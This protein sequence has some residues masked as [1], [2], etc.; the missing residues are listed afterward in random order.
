M[1]VA[2]LQITHMKNLLINVE[3]LILMLALIIIS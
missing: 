2:M 1:L 3:M